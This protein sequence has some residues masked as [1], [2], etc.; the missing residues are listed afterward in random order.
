MQFSD[1]FSLCMFLLRH[2]HRTPRQESLNIFHLQWKE[3]SF[4][5]WNH[6]IWEVQF[7]LTFRNSISDDLCLQLHSQS[8]CFEPS[9][10][11]TPVPFSWNRFQE[12]PFWWAI[13]AEKLLLTLKNILHSLS[14]RHLPYHSPRTSW[15]P[16]S[17]RI[18]LHSISTTPASNW[19]CLRPAACTPFTNIRSYVFCESSHSW[20]RARNAIWLNPTS[21]Y[22][23]FRNQKSGYAHNVRNANI[24]WLH[25]ESC[26]V[27][28]N[29]V[30]SVPVIANHCRKSHCSL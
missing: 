21:G 12:L 16:P 28:N 18:S 5:R 19:N 2:L 20:C 9:V 26:Y 23:F 4:H 8:L 3:L 24:H 10:T 22:R 7:P 6:F 11:C 14:I 15:R 1:A 17:R 30:N 27:H 13:A 29:T 25:S